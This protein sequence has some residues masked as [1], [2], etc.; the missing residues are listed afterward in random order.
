MSTVRDIVKAKGEGVLMIT[1]E[2]P[3]ER[4]AQRMHREHIGAFVVSR[5]G[6]RIDGLITERDIVY[7]IARHGTATLGQPASAVMSHSVHT[8]RLDDS[9][10]SV[11]TTMTNSRVR[12]LPVLEGD[13]V[14][15]I[16]SIGD[17]IKTYVDETDLEAN[18]MRDA[19]LAHRAR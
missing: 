9:V 13:E 17:L 8:C 5:D 3:V 15:G 4:V 12:H 7:G 18:V 19:F 16:V 14:R 10:R 1:P 2:T 6:Y 11:M